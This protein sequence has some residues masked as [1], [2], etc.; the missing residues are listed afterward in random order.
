MDTVPPSINTHIFI[1]LSH[2]AAGAI[3]NMFSELQAFSGQYG[4]SDFYTVY[5]F[6]FV[7]QNRTNRRHA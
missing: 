2:P 6:F 3:R 7:Q 5:I 4:S 1:F